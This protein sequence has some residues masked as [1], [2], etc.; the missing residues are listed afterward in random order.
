MMNLLP[1]NPNSP[2][3]F[4]YKNSQIN[5]PKQKLIKKIYTEPDCYGAS[6]LISRSLRLP[7]T[8][9]SFAYW[10]HGWNFIPLHYKEAFGLDYNGTYLVARKDEEQFLIDNGKKACAIGAPFIYTDLFFCNIKQ[11]RRPNSMLIMPPHGMAYTTEVWNEQNY[12]EEISSV[13]NDFEYTAVCISPNDI[14]KG[15]WINSFRAIGLPIIEGAKMNDLNALLRM[16]TLFSQ[17]E[18]VT[19]SSIG[20]HVA[21][22]AYAGAKVS[23]FGQYQN[24]DADSLRDDGLFKQHP[25]FL[26]FFVE[27]NSEASVRQRYD[28]LFH[29][30]P[31]NASIAIE[32]AEKWLGRDN[33]KSPLKV[34][35]LLNWLPH[36][37]VFY[38][39]QKA[40]SKLRR[41]YKI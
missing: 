10:L 20:S 23:F 11:R 30:H 32:K 21:Y 31:A 12:I 3:S 18:F 14:Q 19:T 8:P 39:A 35:T 1:K 29:T 24:L 37:Q 16:R 4:P 41:V 7:F 33:M 15:S 38:I 34:A 40:Y 36:Q 27:H 22:A 17:F 28:F 5:L 2:S 25:E 13:I 26:Y 9:F 6:S